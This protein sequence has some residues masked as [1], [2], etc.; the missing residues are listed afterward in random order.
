MWTLSPSN[1]WA[2]ACVYE[3]VW[4]R[5]K[6]ASDFVRLSCVPI[7]NGNSCA[8][9]DF[10][11]SFASA[12]AMRC[13]M[14]KIK[15]T[16]WCC[17]ITSHI[18]R[19]HCVV[20]EGFQTDRSKLCVRFSPKNN[21]ELHSCELFGWASVAHGG[22][23]TM[24]NICNCQSALYFETWVVGGWGEP[25]SFLRIFLW[26][27]DSVGWD[28]ILQWHLSLCDSLSTTH[29]KVKLERFASPTN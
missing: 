19:Y 6:W 18:G 26:K 20:V 23:Q 15:Q 29:N 8:F 11:F 4:W 21:T 3:W 1:V 9:C 24:R 5:T 17:Q 2:M 12:N 22:T 13:L 10:I 25:M 28:N 14:W 16:K 27:W 7:R